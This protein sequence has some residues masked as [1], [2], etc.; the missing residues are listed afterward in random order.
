MLAKATF[1]QK[2]SKNSLQ[3]IFSIVFFFPPH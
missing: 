2:Y 1:A 3:F